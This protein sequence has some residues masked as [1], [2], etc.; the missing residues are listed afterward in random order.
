M[1]ISCGQVPGPPTASFSF[2]LPRFRINSFCTIL[3][4]HFFPLLR[5]LLFSLRRFT[6]ALP[7][8]CRTHRPIFSPCCFCR[9]TFPTRHP[10]RRKVNDHLFRGAQP[11]ISSLAELQ[12]LGVTTIVDLRSEGFSTPRKEEQ[13]AAALG[14]RFVRIPVGGFSN[15]TSAQLAQ[16]FSLLRAS[17]DQ[18]FFVHC[19]FGDDR[20]GVFIASYRIAFDH[21]TADQAISEMLASGFNRRWHP[22]MLGFVRALPQRLRADGNLKSALGQPL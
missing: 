17:P 20:T 8:Y 18:K 4:A 11:K 13:Q 12:K 1:P 14:M 22:Y 6:F 9:K 19:E 10:Q 16:F 3:Y 15:P 7:N 5:R 21:W 2:F